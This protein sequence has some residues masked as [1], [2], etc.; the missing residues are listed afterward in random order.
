VPYVRL[1]NPIAADRTVMRRSVLS[2]MLEIL[3]RNIRLRNAWHSSRSVRS[4]YRCLVKNCRSSS[5][6]WQS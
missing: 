5:S 6:A 1:A 4:S 2:T 3:E